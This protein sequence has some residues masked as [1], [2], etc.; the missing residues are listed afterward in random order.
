MLA[1]IRATSASPTR[2]RAPLVATPAGSSASAARSGGPAS[3]ARWRS[4][5]GSRPPAM[6]SKRR[7]APAPVE[8]LAGERVDERVGVVGGAHEEV[9][10]HADADDGTPARRPTSITTVASRI[11][12]PRRRASDDVEERVARVVVVARRRRRSRARRRGGGA[13]R[14]ASASRHPAASAS[15]AARRA[16]GGPRAQHR[17][18]GERRLVERH[19]GGIAGDD[20]GEVVE[21]REL[22]RRRDPSRDGNARY[23]P[24]H[25]PRCLR[26][27]PTRQA[28]VRHGRHRRRSRRS[29][30]S[31]PPPT[32]S[33][34]C[35]GRPA[36]SPATTSRS[37]WRTTPATSRWRGA[38][39]TPAPSTR[40]AR[41][42]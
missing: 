18:D 28:R 33:P 7:R 22:L 36:C 12:R 8:R 9:H 35:C 4:S 14:R 27:H 24:R 30:S 42:A 2:S 16:V 40:R 23:L 3:G 25:V 10:R 31:T 21:P 1:R 13:A 32:G 11:G 6:A 41:R 19:R 15:S 29:P 5:H 37:A 34:A 39:T 38:A 20:G 26:R 17:G